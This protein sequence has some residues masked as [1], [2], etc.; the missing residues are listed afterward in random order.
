M[1]NDE[2]MYHVSLSSREGGDPVN[3]RVALSYGN[4][5]GGDYWMPAYAGMTGRDARGTNDGNQ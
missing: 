3:T 2:A 5:T 1:M 4:R